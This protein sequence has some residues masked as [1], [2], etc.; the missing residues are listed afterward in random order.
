MTVVRCAWADTAPDYVA[1]HDREWGAPLHDERR[2]FEML[3]LEGAQAGLSWLTI[4][5]K[6]DGYRA[7]F[8]GFDA[9]RIARYDEAKQAALLGDARIVR[10][11]LKI[12]AAIAN[13]RATLALREKGGLDPYLWG[14][15]AG[16]P[17]VNRRRSLE[18]IPAE[19]ALSAAIAKDLKRR[20]FRFVGPTT[21]YAFMQSIGM[22]NDHVVDCFRHADLARR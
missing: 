12:A 5:R 17:I 8:D 20:G 3:V 7:A 6:R 2:L 13:A 18:E 19:T 14:F 16:E 10:N 1:Y 4:L 9:E 22:V 11:R 21:V 15:V